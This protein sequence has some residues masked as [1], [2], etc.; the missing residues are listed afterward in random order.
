MGSRYVLLGGSSF[1]GQVLQQQALK[2]R[3][4]ELI[5]LRSRDLDLT[6]TGSGEALAGRMDENTVLIVASRSRNREALLAAQENFAMAVAVGHCLEKCPMRKCIFL[7]SLAVYGASET[8]LRITENTPAL[9]NTYYGASKLA[10]E[11]ILTLAAK[12]HKT[13]LVILR[14]CKIYGPVSLTDGYGPSR[15][16]DLLLQGKEIALYGD[17]EELR[18]HVYAADLARI[19][20]LLAE[21]GATGIFNVASGESHSFRQIIGILERAIGR[22]ARV[23][24]IPRTQP[25]IDQRVCIEKLQEAL[26]AFQP[27]RLE[28]GI[29]TIVADAGA[30]YR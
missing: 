1:V 8:N 15:F 12:K 17:G 22:K 29:R 2:D 13:P 7:S 28:Q 18:D 24:E 6:C 19:I 30:E 5:P 9:P 25:R 3:S 26:P 16:L 27:T 10:S 23:R 4:V 11:Q 14:P 20:L 21:N